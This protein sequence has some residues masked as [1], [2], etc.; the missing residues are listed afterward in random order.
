MTD[1]AERSHS[2]ISPSK[3]KYLEISPA[4][5][6]DPTNEEHPITAEGTLC[7][8]ALDSGNDD[9]LATDEQRGW[10]AQCREYA[11]KVLPAAPNCEHEVKIDVLDGIWGFID[12]VKMMGTKFGA[13]QAAILDWKFG[14]NLQEDVETNPAAQA[15]AFGLFCRYTLLSEIFV[16][17]VYPRLGQIST[18][19]FTRA[20][21]PRIET[22]IRLIV[23]KARDATPETCR[24]SP[25]TCRWCRH[26]ATCP[27]LAKEVLPI[28][29]R[30]AETHS[31]PIPAF[32]DL[33][34][35]NDP[36][37]FARLLSIVP[38]LEAAAESIKRNAV[39][40]RLEEGAEIPGYELRTR[41]GRKK[42][43]NAV[44]AWDVISKLGVTQEQFLRAVD[45]RVTELEKVAG[46][47]APRGK[48]NKLILAMNDALND[49]GILEI[50]PEVTYMQKAK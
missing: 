10:V 32:G 41:A 37:K 36:A 34:T 44:L 21:M 30:Y 20:D 4:F 33:A 14:F 46:E 31:M 27:T 39:R 8:E 17:Y 22:R 49:A 42:V 40:L 48:K 24:W 38:I 12:L 26:R 2:K 15:Y 28:A 19:T 23:E 6:D 35:L 43:L 16:A 7:H 5:E 9:K 1:H 3:L 18:H 50:G 45:V 11:S 25:D 29:T 47:I 13:Y